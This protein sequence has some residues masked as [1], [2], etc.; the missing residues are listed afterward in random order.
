[1]ELSGKYQI[2]I[3]KLREERIYPNSSGIRPAG[4][5]SIVFISLMQNA[6]AQNVINIPKA[7]GA[8]TWRNVDKARTPDFTTSSYQSGTN[9]IP[10]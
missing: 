1:V 6:L 8:R 5:V 9:P 2:L 7:M 4:F 3:E 10:V